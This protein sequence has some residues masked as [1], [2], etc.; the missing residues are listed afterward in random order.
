MIMSSNDRSWQG[1]NKKLK[2]L[3]KIPMF[4]LGNPPM[5]TTTIVLGLWE[6]SGASSIFTL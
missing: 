6:E 2:K 4:A 1:E 3:S 5:F